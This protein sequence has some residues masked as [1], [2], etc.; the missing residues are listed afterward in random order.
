MEYL[1]FYNYD[2][3]EPKAEKIREENAENRLIRQETAKKHRKNHDENGKKPKPKNAG[4]ILAVICL[5]V[6]VVTLGSLLA[7]S[8]YSPTGGVAKNT[9]NEERN[10][11]EL[12]GY[13]DAIDVNLSKIVVS[14]DN[15]KRQK[16]LG[17]VRVQ[18]NLATENLSSLALQDED[19]Y[20]T[21]KFINQISDF[22]KY[23]AEKMIDGE[24]LSSSDIETLK[25]MRD[26]NATLKE[27]LSSLAVD[28]GED[29]EFK[30]LLEGKDGDLVISKFKELE[31]LA[32]EYPHMI[33]DGAFSDGTESAVAKYLDGREEVTKMQA[34]DLLKEYFSAYNLKKVE[35]VGESVGEVIETYNFEATD[36]SGVMLSAQISKKGGL[37]V[38]FNYFK[39]CSEQKIDLESSREVALKFLERAGYKN[40]K[41]VWTTSG[42]SVVT[43]NFASVV[44]G[45]ICYPDLVKV[46]VCRER[47]IVSGLEASSYIYNHV[48]RESQTAIVSLATAKQKVD[49]EI[50]IETS[51]L[52]I[53][54]K[55]E[56]TE[57]LAYEFYGKCEDGYYYIFI[58][59]QTGKEL[60]IFK[61][62]DS[63]EGLLL[64]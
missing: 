57:V 8:M 4:W 52:A 23:L 49:Q 41:A 33:Y 26:I 24:S 30:S 14:K 36:D 64:L 55:G 56:N 31:T 2:I 16:L 19:K 45:V 6:A 35:L 27:N 29:Y 54:P 9:V 5:S 46:N 63:T 13:V 34:E 7:Y 3:N 25:K 18:S 15:E 44:Q 1:K 40:L 21:L 59:A 53:I 28:M 38:Q 22:S 61:V 42:G 60:D 58:D 43:I 62:I 10:F 20:L 39:E 11:Y 17:E 12:V 48:E 32:S 37:L 47:G 51:R 50:S